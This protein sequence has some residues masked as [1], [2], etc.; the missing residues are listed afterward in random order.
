MIINCG[1][2][3]ARLCAERE[4][5]IDAALLDDDTRELICFEAE[6]VHV[7]FA[8]RH[9]ARDGCTRVE[10]SRVARGARTRGDDGSCADDANGNSCTVSVSVRTR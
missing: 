7:R 3:N 4:S 9:L 1:E 2:E 10:L 5:N 8:G 6:E